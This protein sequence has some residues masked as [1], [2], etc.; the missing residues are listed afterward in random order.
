VLIAMKMLHTM[1]QRRLS[2]G[3]FALLLVLSLFSF[4]YVNLDAAREQGRA[5]LWSR[6]TEKVL[7]E[8]ERGQ[9]PHTAPGVVW[10]SRL[11]DLLLRFVSNA[12][13]RY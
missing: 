6:H 11:V 5:S 2:R 13:N 8:E 3:G 9:A 4:F 10:I 12:P 7:E 1:K